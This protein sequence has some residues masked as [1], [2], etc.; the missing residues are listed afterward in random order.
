M[1]KSKNALDFALITMQTC[2][3]VTDYFF[4]PLHRIGKGSN[5]AIANLGAGDEISFGGKDIEVYTTPTL[6]T[7]DFA[8]SEQLADSHYCSQNAG[9]V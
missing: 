5:P 2:K 7:D 9:G 4:H 1:A 3:A 8:N 6:D